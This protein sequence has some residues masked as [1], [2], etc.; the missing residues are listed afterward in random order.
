MKR[1]ISLLT[2][3]LLILAL[4]APALAAS[5][6]N[7][8]DE[9]KLGVVGV[10]AGLVYDENGHIAGTVDGGSRGTGFGIGPVGQNAQYFL[11]N[12]HVVEASIDNGLDSYICIDGANFEDEKTLIHCEV[13]YYDDEVDFA[14]LRTEKP[15]AGVKTLPLL[16]TEVHK[17]RMSTT[18]PVYA[19]GYPGIGDDG[20]E[21]GQ[22]RI[23]DMTVTNGIISRF[24]VSDN[25]VSNGIQCIAHTAKINGGNSGGPLVNDKGQVIGINT[26]THTDPN[27]ADKRDYAIY[28]DYPMEVL[29][30]MGV[31]YIDASRQQGGGGS[32]SWLEENLTMVIVGAGLAVLVLLVVVKALGTKKPARRGSVPA[33]A[34]TPVPGPA[35]VPNM[36][37]L[38]RQSPAVRPVQVRVAMNG[39]SKVWNL[40]G[41]VKVGRSHECEIRL[42]NET[43]G[44]SRIHCV[45]SLE[46]GQVYV[47]DLGSTYG[48]FL[49]GNRIPANRPVA[50]PGNGEV[51]IG[52][53]NVRLNIQ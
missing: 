46:G 9:A 18:D 50:V 25:T 8:V 47:T 13:L 44:V 12:H 10:F 19:M 49:N 53:G 28:I 27:T 20:V 2:A 4:A 40:T 7:P 33:P 45:L 26:W 51:C 23:E 17:E 24:V 41:R 43:K 31:E 30:Q 39:V 22:F 5:E 15:V 29:D 34:P 1:I 42:P 35:P 16:S 6:K 52:S 21:M 11:T 48:T 32:G 14:I 36:E 38:L 3:C 37:P